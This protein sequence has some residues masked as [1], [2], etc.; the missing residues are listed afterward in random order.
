MDNVLDRYE[1][2][3]LDMNGTFMFGEDRFGPA[4][5]YYATY[6][7]LSGMRLTPGAVRRA[8]DDCYG[9]MA[10]LYEDSGAYRRLPASA[11]GAGPVA[12]VHAGCRPPRSKLVEGVIA[13][14]ELGRVP[15]EYAAALHRLAATHRL[16]VVTNLWSRKPPW[17]D[18]LRR[19]GVLDLFAA[20]AVLVGWPVA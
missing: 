3:L 20:V 10:A 6:R 9:R 17:L 12:G 7:G 18:E 5:D 4:Q 2:V 8:V 13:R 14:H 15:D 16:G 19:A 11:G 1:A